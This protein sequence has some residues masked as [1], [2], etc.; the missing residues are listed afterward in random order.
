MYGRPRMDAAAQ[1]SDDAGRPFR[2]T[3]IDQSTSY[4]SNDGQTFTP[5]EQPPELTDGKE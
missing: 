2:T 3:G 4:F 1:T 5:F